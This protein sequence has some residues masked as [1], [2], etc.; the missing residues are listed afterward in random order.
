MPYSP[1]ERETIPSLNPLSS[2]ASD[3][4]RRHRHQPRCVGHSDQ[5][6]KTFYKANELC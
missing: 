3:K 2:R 4:H 5:A 6:L 1:L